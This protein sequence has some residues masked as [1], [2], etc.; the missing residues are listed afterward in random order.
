MTAGLTARPF[1]SGAYRIGVA[2]VSGFA[3]MTDDLGARI[4]VPW[5]DGLA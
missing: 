1:Q 5:R 2:P 3:E 4:S